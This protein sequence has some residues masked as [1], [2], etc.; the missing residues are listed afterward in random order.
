VK[1][2]P[3]VQPAEIKPGTDAEDAAR[4]RA[5]MS[6]ARIRVNGSAHPPHSNP[7]PDSRYL[8][9]EFWSASNVPESM[10]GQH[11]LIRYTDHLLRKR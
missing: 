1:R 2:R 10:F 3:L 4:W 8:A 5:L 11:A 9:I 6:S 7:V